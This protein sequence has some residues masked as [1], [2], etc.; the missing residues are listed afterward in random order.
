MNKMAEKL[1]Y[2]D[3]IKQSDLQL[4]EKQLDEKWGVGVLVVN[5]KIDKMGEDLKKAL[6][7]ANVAKLKAQYAENVEE[8]KKK[9]EDEG[10]DEKQMKI[11]LKAMGKTLEK[12]ADALAKTAELKKKSMLDLC[13]ANGIG[14]GGNDPRVVSHCNFVIAKMQSEAID[15]VR[16]QTDS[17][18][19][20]KAKE[21]L[22]ELKKKREDIEK[23]EKEYDGKPADDIPVR[24][25][26]L[27]DTDE[28]TIKDL[29]DEAG[30]EKNDNGKEEKLYKRKYK[31]PTELDPPKGFEKGS[32]EWIDLNNP[33]TLK[34]LGIDKAPD[35]SAV[36]IP[37][38]FKKNWYGEKDGQTNQL[39]F[40]PMKGIDEIKN[41]SDYF[42]VNSEK[43][44]LKGKMGVTKENVGSKL[45]AGIKNA[46]DSNDLMSVIKWGTFLGGIDEST[47]DIKLD[48][49]FNTKK[50][51]K[52]IAE[53]GGN[54]IAYMMQ[55]KD[56]FG[57]L[58]SKSG[59]DKFEY[60]YSVLPEK[61]EG[62]ERGVNFSKNKTNSETYFNKVK[63]HID[64]E[65]GKLEEIIEKGVTDKSLKA[66]KK[67]D[68]GETPKNIFNNLKEYFNLLLPFK[69]GNGVVMQTLKDRIDQAE[70]GFTD[71]FIEKFK[72]YGFKLKESVNIESREEYLLNAKM[73]NEARKLKDWLQDFV[74]KI[75]SAFNDSKEAQ[76][77]TGIVPPM[78]D[79]AETAEKQEKED[80][81]SSD[82]GEEEKGE[83]EGEQEEYVKKS[84]EN[85][86]TLKY[87]QKIAN[88]EIH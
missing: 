83:D 36:S 28:E 16:K 13:K 45:A 72:K 78:K 63:E 14:K 47:D 46:E 8:F 18:T 67:D 73:L 37:D 87:M 35:L 84:L 77:E 25:S 74:D 68:A 79:A 33:D 20:D 10:T 21:A 22:D 44:L 11:K 9:L 64:S 75:K 4:S 32:G 1:S 34:K 53:N 24:Q 52:N 54:V 30:T 23:K 48:S 43:F 60:V 55:N 65:L 59:L 51:N 80:G 26:E 81:G 86:V 2:E 27:G 61:A 69:E 58:I 56:K 41:V 17:F 82:E 6:I 40:L 7:E 70:E 49:L 3:Y 19:D 42:D 50:E 38:E 39:V 57:E 85:E 71:A 76:D 88:I 29:Y 62:E 5:K 15:E 12:K 31:S 66:D